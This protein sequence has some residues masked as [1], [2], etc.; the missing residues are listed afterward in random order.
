MSLVATPTVPPALLDQPQS[1][2][3]CVDWTVLDPSGAYRRAFDVALPHVDQVADPFHVIRLANSSIDEVRP[4]VH[5]DTLGRR[6]RKATPSIGRGGYSFPPANNSANVAT[7]DSRSPDP[8]TRTLRSQ[9][10]PHRTRRAR[11]ARSGLDGARE[12]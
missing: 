12:R 8:R 11:F 10:L 2:R 3:K 6:G 9:H 7:P 4:S 1:W 5:N